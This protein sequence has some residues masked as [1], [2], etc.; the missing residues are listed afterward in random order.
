M[1][2]TEASLYI[3]LCGLVVVFIFA[4][5]TLS[6]ANSVSGAVT[7]GHPI[8][9]L[10]TVTTPK[11]PPSFYSYNSYTT[12]TAAGTGTGD[13]HVCDPNSDDNC[14]FK[15]PFMSMTTWMNVYGGTSFVWVAI[16]A[17]CVVFSL[18]AAVTW[19]PRSQF[20]ACT[21]RGCC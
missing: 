17:S 9:E 16:R 18:L 5:Y 8:G 7:C 20:T 13:D 21:R 15:Q 2:W 14:V 3:R 12:T 11:S 4:I 10:K 1:S 19:M 6:A